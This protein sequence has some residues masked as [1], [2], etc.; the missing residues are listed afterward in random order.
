MINLFPDLPIIRHKQK[1]TIA[2][3]KA[4]E[5]DDLR[6]SN[7]LPIDDI[8]KY[9]LQE[10]FLK[11]GLKSF[12]D[13]RK[14]FDIPIEALLLPQVLQRLNDEHSLLLAPY[15]LN[16]A[17]LMTELGYSARVLEEGFNNKNTYERVTPFH[18]E[19]LKHVLLSTKVDQ[20]FNWFNTD[21]NQ[22][23]KL[24]A[25]GRTR[26]YIIDGT[27]I[28]VPK[29][30]YKKYDGAGVVTNN[31]GEVRYGYKVVWI[32]EIIDR[33]GVIRSMT[34]SPIQTHDLKLGKELIADFDFEEGA[35]L[36][37]DR[38]FL[39]GEWITHLKYDRKI[40]VCMPLK[41]NSEI[42]QFAIA[43]AEFDNKWQPHP[44]REKQ[45]IC[46]IKKSELEWSL[47]QSF[48]SGVLVRFT[49]K[50]GEE[51]NIV[52]VDTRAGISGKNILATYDQRTEI[53]ESHRQMKCFQGLEK[54]PSKKLV[55][56][57]FRIIMG[58]IAYNLFNL[59]LNS[60]KC[61]TLEDYTLKTHR[62]RRRSSERNPE[63]IIYTGDTYAILNNL[64]F[65]DIILTLKKS[66]QMKL[67]KIF[68]ELTS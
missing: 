27:E 17:E 52:F 28:H 21:W 5:I 67:R 43:Q 23:M 9:G 32:Q 14:T 54:L 68:K 29:H 10:N 34:M 65:L 18:G 7:K 16:S 8:V 20:L 40:D 12:P 66:T 58:T 11:D 26:Q 50:N 64:D 42:T 33:K 59:F 39:D 3:L 49:K 35:L 46:E 62:Q 13:P 63:I 44:T 1:E 22:L 48:N 36:L 6:V 57:V 24:N 41:C 37:M 30:L 19:T 61:S 60:E 31:E 15:M 56:V 38:G 47:C 2:N 53:E 45:K 55:H 4:G 25:P 51:E